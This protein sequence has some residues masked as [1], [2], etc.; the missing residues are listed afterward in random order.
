M[1]TA[2]ERQPEI[3]TGR[4]ETYPTSDSDQTT[5]KR[6]VV[7]IAVDS[8]VKKVQG[9]RVL[10]GKRVKTVVKS[11]SGA[12][13]NDMFDYI[14]PTIRQHPEH[15]ISHVGTNDLR[16]ANPGTVTAWR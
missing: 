13:V 12:S 14:T 11:F 16:N 15:I 1:D 6:P 5:V 4:Q 3:N 9:W 2:V 8:L 10:N 7:V